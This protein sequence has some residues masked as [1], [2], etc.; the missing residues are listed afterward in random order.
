LRLSAEGQT[1]VAFER[2]LGQ[3]RDVTGTEGTARRANRDDLHAVLALDRE[4]PVAHE[5]QALLTSRVE[6]S[7]VIILENGEL[8]RGYAVLRTRAFFGR[9][10]VELLAVAV[11]QR[12]RGV[13]TLLLHHAV[14][15]SSTPR[16][17]TSTNQ[18]NVAMIRLLEK[19]GW[20][21]SGR[22][23]GIDEGDPE[24]VYFK[25]SS[26][27]EHTMTFVNPESLA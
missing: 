25:D 22:L 6:S 26:S 20:R 14:E 9:D 15:M 16:V 2:A 5:R 23:E 17:F 13:G 24:L 3:N 19:A 21:P 1:P 8:V 12:R 27:S 11:D 10:F 4:A 7:E 18:S